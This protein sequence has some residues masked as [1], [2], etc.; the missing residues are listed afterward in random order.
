MQVKLICPVRAV[1]LVFVLILICLQNGESASLSQRYSHNGT[2]RL[3]TVPLSGPFRLMHLRQLV[4]SVHA[5][6]QGLKP[7]SNLERW[8]SR[9]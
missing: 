9:T 7:L 1:T 8:L 4:V 2:R 6:A 3:I 5:G